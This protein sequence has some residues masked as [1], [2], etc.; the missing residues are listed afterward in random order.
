[1]SSRLQSTNH[2]RESAYTAN[3]QIAARYGGATSSSAVLVLDAPASTTVT[4]AVAMV[5]AIPIPRLDQ[6]TAA[7][8][9]EPDPSGA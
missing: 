6:A 1:M 4:T 9:C 7:D 8:G 3:T 5:F 2:V